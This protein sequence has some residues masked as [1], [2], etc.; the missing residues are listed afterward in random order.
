M[1]IFVKAKPLAK[2][3]HIEKIDD[4]NFIVSVKEPPIKGLA[5]QAIINA[6][7][8]YFDVPKSM[9]KLVS[10]YSSRQKTFEITQ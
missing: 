8:N 3:E 6:L 7:A 1:R 10:G 4:N 9:V 2:E 5:N